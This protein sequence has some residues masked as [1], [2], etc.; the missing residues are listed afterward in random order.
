MFAEAAVPR[1]TVNAVPRTSALQEAE[2]T[3]LYLGI[4]STAGTRLELPSMAKS[5]VA[6]HSSL[7]TGWGQRGT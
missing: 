3:G 4:P 1:L 5:S 2:C 7:E 6:E